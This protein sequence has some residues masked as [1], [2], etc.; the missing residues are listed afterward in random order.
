[1]AMSHQTLSWRILATFHF[2][3]LWER[4]VF[5]AAQFPVIIGFH[6]EN[7][8]LTSV[9]II[10]ISLFHIDNRFTCPSH[11]PNYTH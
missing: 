1:M 11:F 3:I 4:R 5:F 10:H 2:N 9:P 7:R 8:A 6:V